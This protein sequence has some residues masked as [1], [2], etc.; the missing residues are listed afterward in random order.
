MWNPTSTN[1]KFT[2]LNQ[3]KTIYLLCTFSAGVSQAKDNSIVNP[4]KFFP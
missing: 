2:A 4:D 3:L 1:L